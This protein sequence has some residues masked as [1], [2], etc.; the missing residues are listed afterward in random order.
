MRFLI[1]I[2]LAVGFCA[3]AF[4]AAP[5]FDNNAW[6]FVFVPAFGSAPNTNNL[7]VAEL[8]HSLRFGQLLSLQT[9]GRQSNIQGMLAFALE[10]NDLAPLQTIEPFALLTNQAIKSR[11][12]SIGSVSSYGTAKYWIH[13]ILVNQPK[14]IYVIS[15]PKAVVTDMVKELTGGCG[16]FKQSGQYIVV[17]GQAG[18]LVANVFDDQLSAESIYPL[19]PLP[20]SQACSVSKKTIKVNVPPG[21]KPYQSQTVFFVRHV[22]AHPSGNFEN[23]NYVCQGQWRALGATNILAKLMDDKKP[24]SIVSSPPNGLIDC[25]GTCSYIRPLLT[26]T[27]FAIQHGMPVT[28]APFDWTDATDL[29]YWLFDKSSPYTTKAKDKQL[30][31]VGWEH[32]HIVSAVQ[33]IIG[34]VYNSP[35][36]VKELPPWGF[37]DY[38]SVWKLSTDGHGTLTFT[39]TCEGIPTAQLPSVCPA[40]FQDPLTQ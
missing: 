23:G 15:A 8:N 7:T 40:F 25:G 16:T 29:A 2:L 30:I 27:P 21:L 5:S 26:V 39:N 4:A 20:K 35:N 14:G 6:N 32:G 28:L 36:Q 9:A 34:K 3:P 12:V 24:D 13:D 38:D 18:R 17:S 31:L 22:E 1:G 33:A 10:Q 11:T 19:V 37:D